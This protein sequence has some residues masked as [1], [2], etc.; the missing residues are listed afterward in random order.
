MKGIDI[1]NHQP[2]VDFNAL[3]NSVEIVIMKA[4]EGITYL[5]SKL[6]SHYQGAKAAGFPVGFYHFMS[7]KT[8]P[9]EQATFFYNAIKDKQFEIIPLLDIETNS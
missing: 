4:T 8:S 5:D 2:S 1:S 9:S 6:G 7:E 3:K